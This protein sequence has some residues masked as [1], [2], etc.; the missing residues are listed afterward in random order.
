VAV[1]ATVM[2]R[3]GPEHAGQLVGQRDRGLVLAAT[4]FDIKGEALQGIQRFAAAF[5]PVRSLKCGSGAVYEQGSQI[6]IA[7]LA[8]APEVTLLA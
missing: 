2:N 1:E 6:G 4:L 8:D 7:A 3:H 5:G